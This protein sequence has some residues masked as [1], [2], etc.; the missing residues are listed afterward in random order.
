MHGDEGALR[1]FAV[2][3]RVG[4][5]ALGQDFLRAELRVALLW[6]DEEVLRGIEYRN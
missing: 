1:D 6:L 4:L 3:Q 5:G 2:P